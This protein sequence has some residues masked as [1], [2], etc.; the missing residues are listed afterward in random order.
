MAAT[1]TTRESARPAPTS[2]TARGDVI[3]GGAGADVILGDN[4]AIARR[5][6]GAGTWERYP[7]PFADVVRDA[8][9]FDDA[10]LV[11]GDD[12]LSGG[13]G[14]D[15]VHGQRGNDVVEG[16]S[17]DDE[18]YGELG[19]DTLAGGEGHEVVLGDVGVVTRAYAGGAPRT[20]PNGGW[21][22][23]VLLTDVGAIAG[24]VALTGLNP[25]T[26]IATSLL[27]SELLLLTGSYDADGDRQLSGPGAWDT[28]IL[29]LT[30]LADG[31]GQLAGD[32]GD[33]AL[34]GQRGNDTLS[35][36]EGDDCVEGDA[37][38]DTVD[39][40]AGN[41]HV[42]GDEGTTV[43]TAESARPNVR[44]G[45]HVIATA[46]SGE[47]A[48]GIVL[49]QF[50]SVVAPMLTTTPLNG[51]RALVG[52][53]PYVAGGMSAIPAPNALEAVDG[54]S[55][56][57]FVAVV[58]RI[59]GHLHLLAGDDSVTGG[60]GDDVVIGDAS[61]VFA[62]GVTVTVGLLEAGD[63]LVEEAGDVADAWSDLA[64]ALPHVVGLDDG[65]DHDDTIVVDR[66]FTVG[67]DVVDGGAGNGVVIG[68]DGVVIAPAVT[69]AV[70]QVD[71]LHEL[72]H[73]MDLVD[74]ALE[75]V[76]GGV[77]GRGARGDGGRPQ[78]SHPGRRASHQRGMRR[79]P[80]P[81]RSGQRLRDRLA[82]APHAQVLRG[83]RR[84][85]AGQG[86]HR[87]PAAHLRPDAG[88]SGA[89][90][91]RHPGGAQV[92]AGRGAGLARPRD[93][94]ARDGPRVVPDSSGLGPV[95][96]GHAMG[97]G[98]EG[99]A[100]R[101]RADPGL[102]GLTGQLDARARAGSRLPSL[103]EQMPC[104]SRKASIARRHSAGF[105][106]CSRCPVPGIAS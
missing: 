14:A 96:Q 79:H 38:H 100:R 103:Q 64:H 8:Q 25:S 47:A 10:D 28:R 69:I 93:A 29:L 82:G 99:A 61:T 102:L 45:L 54:T 89:G 12:T 68:D 18:L 2:S 19:D 44:H 94:A 22:R 80:A 26:W 104:S 97:G 37:G 95:A 1:G 40:G 48:A 90:G 83:P 92:F 63:W 74:E 106:I 84:R 91:S 62:P 55:M 73:E 27:E 59:A 24:S 15:M 46:T 41:D 75:D 86:D 13:A 39:G 76:G 33:D 71:E 101:S 7:A 52:L 65:D 23:A 30:L 35:G 60:T 50:G 87:E 42:V 56:V 78:H 11:S 4:G 5:L 66:T 43:V 21:H 6:T 32:A 67:Q 17:G 81:R 34:F 72:L 98:G 70:G 36:G 57:P 88:A 3:D 53:L 58:P 20:K 51:T 16:G 77:D 105:W 31:A 49:G 9:R 85:S